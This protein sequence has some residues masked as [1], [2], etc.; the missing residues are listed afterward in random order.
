MKLPKDSNKA[1]ERSL[2]HCDLTGKNIFYSYLIGKEPELT[3][4]A[5]ERRPV[6]NHFWMNF[7]LVY[8]LHVIS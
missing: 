2:A 3:F 5:V 8:K 7:D 6:V 4:L 1:F